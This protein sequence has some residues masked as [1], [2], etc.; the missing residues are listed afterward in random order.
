MMT[1]CEARE[2]FV[3]AALCEKSLYASLTE[4]R[5]LL[6]DML[7]VHEQEPTE[8]PILAALAAF[9]NKLSQLNSIID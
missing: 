4:L 6:I 3:K 7:D 2:A 8:E 1:M 9:E 5:Q